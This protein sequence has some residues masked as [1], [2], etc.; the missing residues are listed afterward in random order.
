MYSLGFIVRK[1]K[2]FVSIYLRELKEE[3]QNNIKNTDLPVVRYVIFTR[4][5]YY[6]IY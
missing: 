2:I 5:S 6:T 3:F 4:E 1:T